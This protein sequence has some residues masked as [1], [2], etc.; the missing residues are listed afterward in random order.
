MFSRFHKLRLSLAAKCELLFGGAVALVIAAA[1]FVPWLRMEQLTLQSNEQTA[2][3]LVQSVLD[4]H[5]TAQ[6]ALRAA[7]PASRPAADATA[8]P[9]ARQTASDLQR[10]TTQPAATQPSIEGNRFGP[11]HMVLLRDLAQKG[12]PTER[13]TLQS[14]DKERSADFYAKLYRYDGDYRYRFGRLILLEKTCAQC[15]Q[16]P[17][18]GILPA[19]MDDLPAGAFA[20]ASVDIPSQVQPNQ[21]LL[22]RMFIFT[23][24]LVAGSLAIVIFYL[25]ISRLILQPVR[26]LQET[27]EKVSEGDLN[28]RTHIPT[29][30]E[31]QVLS[32]TFNRML[33]N[34]KAGEDQLR[35]INKSLDLKLEQMKETN[36][37][38]YESNRLKS[39]F[40]ANVSHELRTPL[41]S[42]LGFAELLKDAPA[43][44]ADT[45][46]VRYIQ[47]ILR[48]G[49]N[50]LELINDLLDLAKIEAGRM[51]V[52]AEPLSLSDLFEGLSSILK[53][54]LEAK[55]LSIEASVG[56]DVPLM[57]TDAAKLQQI[58]YNFLSNAIK[59]SPAGD[60]IRLEARRHDAEQV[61]IVVSDRGPGVPADKQAIIFEKFRQVDASHTREHGGTGL[62]LSISKELTHLLGGEL[63]VSS[64]E[65]GGA[66]FW[67]V[68]PLKIQSQSHDVRDGG[69]LGVQSV[70][71]GT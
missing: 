69:G 49:Q 7:E 67:M 21:L 61:K 14:V 4:S 2:R 43:I 45:K 8:E 3:A 10:A 51:E 32:E 9:D 58:L 19:D 62:G 46:G 30:D 5:L 26:V 23:A 24:A 33:E 36:L 29:D 16:T 35:S 64:A 42:I 28:I 59:F 22:N 25:I 56:T 48:S 37:A 31:F 34:L 66:A 53:P 65:G 17:A 12:T 70:E 15:H 38:L 11:V 50:L 1:V 63:G 71:R 40:L 20:V 55:S 13:R 57:T 39:E 60:W 41:N 18:H 27:A 44:S 52:R 6:Q 68:L 54:L 47:N